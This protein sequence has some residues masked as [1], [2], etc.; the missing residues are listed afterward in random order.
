MLVKK[1][2]M[3]GIILEI[4]PEK[5]LK[6]N[7]IN[8]DGDHPTTSTVTDQLT[9]ENGKMCIRDRPKVGPLQV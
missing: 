4:E 7:L 2:E 9:Y 1:I 3:N 8:S 6:Y 5:L